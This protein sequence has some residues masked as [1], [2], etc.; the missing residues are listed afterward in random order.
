MMGLRWQLAAGGV[1]VALAAASALWSAPAYAVT[2]TI[3]E[4]QGGGDDGRYTVIAADGKAND[5]TISEDDTGRIVVEDA[6]DVITGAFG[7]TLADSHRAVC[8]GGS[9]IDMITVLAGDL[10][11]RISSTVIFSV[12]LDGGP[13]NDT[14]S[15][16][17]GVGG[18]DR[19][20][21]GGA[22]NDVINGGSFID[23]LL[24]GAG[25]DTLNGNNGGDR[26]DG[27]PGEDRL[28][29]GADN[30][31][32]RSSDTAADGADVFDGG[33]G[34]D[35]VSYASRTGPVAVTLDGVADDGAAGEGDNQVNVESAAGGAGADTLTGNDGFNG[36]SGGP[37][38]DVL[39][40]LAGPDV[41]D[42]GEGDDAMSGGPGPASVADNDTI[43]GGAGVDTVRYA[44]RTVPLT[45]TLDNMDFDGAAGERDNVFNSV[46]NL[47]GGTA[48]DTFTGTDQPNRLI[49]AGGNDTL[50][51]RGGADLLAGGNGDDTLNG[52]DTVSGNDELRGGS[53][54]A[55]TCASDPAD[56]ESDCEL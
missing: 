4:H 19:I 12:V 10:D 7:C 2:G 45:V 41:L 20:M 17:R 48:G 32:A 26:L 55:D 35:N 15:S 51:G 28:F 24:G 14:I 30:D 27:G 38:N 39:D 9:D 52:V 21:N 29:G 33:P 13:G 25:S 49:G 44:G 43:V 1:F 56:I 53:G 18:T 5:I 40:A 34:V 22:G 46:E 42:G 54:T 16:A 31:S 23:I 6:G 11:D 3:V 36:L 37:G 50:T 47:E 8:P